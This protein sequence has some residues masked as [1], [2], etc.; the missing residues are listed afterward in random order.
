MTDNID[1]LKKEIAEIIKESP[2]S[3][4]TRHAELTL[5]WLVILKPDADIA[6]QIAAL[7]H[8]IDRGV[9]KITD[10]HLKNLNDYD[11]VRR[12]HSLRSVEIMADLLKKYHIDK[13]LAEN[14]LH[15]VEFHEIGGDEYSDI[16]KDADS[17]AFFE[18]NIPGYL[19]R[20]NKE[21]TLVKM[22]YMFDR[23]SSSRAKDIIKDMNYDNTEIKEL[24]KK[25]IKQ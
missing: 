15:L 14:I 23:I 3:S 21:K 7:S 5:K 10:S 6:M 9:N 13:N 2:A 25:S 19:K 8:D 22:K 24:V 16:L 20:N 4:D 18:F 11:K 17:L 12:E 1:Q